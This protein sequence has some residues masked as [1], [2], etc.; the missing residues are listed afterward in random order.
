M[1]ESLTNSFQESDHESAVVSNEFRVRLILYFNHRMPYRSLHLHDL[2]PLQKFVCDL[3]K[4]TSGKSLLPSRTASKNMWEKLG[5]LPVTG[6]PQLSAK[7]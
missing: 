3:S 5:P 1:L 4:P 6:T 2:P 7:D